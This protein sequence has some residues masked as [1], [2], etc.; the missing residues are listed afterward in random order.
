MQVSY[1]NV[2]QTMT[3]VSWKRNTFKKNYK[4]ILWAFIKLLI[5]FY[6]LVVF[7]RL[8]PVY[9]TRKRRETVGFKKHQDQI[10]GRV[11]SQVHFTKK[12]QCSLV[13]ILLLYSSFTSSY[14]GIVIT[15]LLYYKCSTRSYGCNSISV[16]LAHP[17]TRVRTRQ[18]PNVYLLSGLR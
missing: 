11:Q 5:I 10:Q 15:A 13:D 3:R 16:V 6:K 9:V 12:L 18:H 17:R 4:C 7:I 14:P 8:E 1:I 2:P